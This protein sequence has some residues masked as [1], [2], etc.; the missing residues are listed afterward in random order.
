M[1]YTCLTYKA[2]YYENVIK[3]LTVT[4]PGRELPMLDFHV[5]CDS[6]KSTETKWVTHIISAVRVGMAFDYLSNYI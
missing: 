6:N 1:K 3:V 4:V 5:L 2:I